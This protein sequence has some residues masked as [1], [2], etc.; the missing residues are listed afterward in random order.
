VPNG[1]G[2][3]PPP[4]RARQVG[5]SRRLRE[6]PRN[7]SCASYASR[8][9]IRYAT[10]RNGAW[11]TARVDAVG[12][13]LA[14]GSDYG[15][16][17]VSIVASASGVPHLAYQ[18]QI[19]SQGVWRYATGAPG[20]WQIETIDSGDADGSIALDREGVPDVAYS[21][22]NFAKLGVRYAKRQDNRWSPSVVASGTTLHCGPEATTVTIPIRVSRRHRRDSASRS[23]AAVG[24]ERPTRTC[25]PLALWALSAGLITTLRAWRRQRA[26]R[27]FR[28]DAIFRAEWSVTE[29][30][31]NRAWTIVMVI[32]SPEP[33]QLEARSTA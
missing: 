15:R 33:A 11:L 19:A 5:G 31:A 30:L 26:G 10:N 14:T 18:S 21:F 8:D 3:P 23:N 28:L 32:A 16:P 7:L 22:A 27:E 4:G 13:D 2:V 24:R 20:S 17:T 29:T 1:C 6:D 12:P 25:G 9:E